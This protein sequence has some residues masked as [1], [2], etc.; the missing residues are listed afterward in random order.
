MTNYNMTR[1]KTRIIHASIAILALSLGALGIYMADILYKTHTQGRKSLDIL[2]LED[3]D[4]DVDGD[5]NEDVN[6]NGDNAVAEDIGPA[7]GKDGDVEIR[8]VITPVIDTFAVENTLINRRPRRAFVAIAQVSA[9][10]SCG[11]FAYATM[12]GSFSKLDMDSD[13]SESELK[14]EL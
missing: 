12:R 5:V 6:E 14:S 4:G 2:A 7:V 13:A 10:I 8:E 11:I 9:V 3:I 1:S